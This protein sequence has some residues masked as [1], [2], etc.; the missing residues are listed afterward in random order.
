MVDNGAVLFHRV[1]EAF[2]KRANSAEVPADTAVSCGPDV[3]ATW[4][5]FP[6]LV[7][8]T[9]ITSP[10]DSEPVVGIPAF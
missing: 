4:L 9:H 6:A 10:V 7:A 2:C 3:L 8:G 1:G 5:Q